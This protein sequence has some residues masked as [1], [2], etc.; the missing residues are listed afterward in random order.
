MNVLAEDDRWA[1]EAIAGLAGPGALWA[2][3]TRAFAIDQID[4]AFAALRDG[5]VGKIA[6]HP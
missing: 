6:V 5:A 2:A 1:L 4:A 3:I